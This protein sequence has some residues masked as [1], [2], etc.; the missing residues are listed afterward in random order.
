MIV[1]SLVFG[2]CLAP[3]WGR[4]ELPERAEGAAPAGEAERGPSLCYVLPGLRR[5]RRCCPGK[6]SDSCSLT[7]RRPLPGWRGR[8]RRDRRGR[9][10]PP[11]RT[12]L[13]RFLAAFVV[14]RECGG[15]HD[16]TDVLTAV[17]CPVRCALGQGA[18]WSVL[19]QGCSCRGPSV[20]P[21]AHSSRPEGKDAA[22]PGPR[23]RPRRG[24]GA[25]LTLDA[26]PKGI[27]GGAEARPEPLGREQPQRVP[28][29][30]HRRGAWALPTSYLP[31]EPPTAPA[32]APQP[33]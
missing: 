21:S 28:G 9:M 17:G 27:W 24:H 30:E 3:R 26:A 14:G 20:R 4:R 33:A 5:G 10:R 29:R 11:L 12:S 31:A 16:P 15:G 8:D 23:G 2:G 32:T 13:R 1:G 19:G 25:P 18:V 7:A 6:A 22:A